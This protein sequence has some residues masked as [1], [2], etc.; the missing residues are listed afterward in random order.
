[1]TNRIGLD[2]AYCATLSRIREQK[3]N[4]GK[5]GICTDVDF[6][7]QEAVEC[8]RAVPCVRGRGRNYGPQRSQYPV[9]KDLV[10]LH[11]GTC[12]S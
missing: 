9:S 7:F 5:F 3:G 10:E 4:K 6:A 2:D 12:Y 11:S 8:T 1:M